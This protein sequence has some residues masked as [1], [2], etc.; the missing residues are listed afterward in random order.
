[1]LLRPLRGWAALAL[2]CFGPGS[3]GS[4]A[5]GPGSQ[6]VQRGAWPSGNARLGPAS[7]E[8][9]CAHLLPAPGLPEPTRAQA[10]PPR[11]GISSPA[12]AG[13]GAAFGSY[14]G[15]RPQ[16]ARGG[17]GSAPGSCSGMGREALKSSPNSGPP[18]RFLARFFRPW[19]RWGLGAALS[20]F[21][22]HS[23]ASV[24]EGVTPLALSCPPREWGPTQKRVTLTPGFWCPPYG[25]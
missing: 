11:R 7:Q 24:G 16:R 23:G 9:L 2:R 10:P 5:S 15:A 8:P 17:W 12:A 14:P 13:A 22:S 6:R 19:G 18:T 3:P 20:R 21:F 1:M 25:C 4:P